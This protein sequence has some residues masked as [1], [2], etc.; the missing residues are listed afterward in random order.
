MKTFLSLVGKSCLFTLLLSIPLS[1]HAQAVYIVSG[2]VQSVMSEPLVGANVRLTSVKQSGDTYGMATDGKGSFAIQLPQGEYNLEISYLGY[3]SYRACVQVK[4]DVRLPVISLNEESQMMETVV[5]TAHTMTY[6]PNGYVAEIAKNPSYRG[7]SLNE[8]LKLTPGTHTTHNSVQL[9]GRNVS[10]IYLNGREL[11]LGGEQLVN[12][13]ETLDAKN[14]KR[15]EV[16][17]ASGVEEDAVNKGRSVI[18]ITTVNPETGGMMNAGGSY[19]NGEDKHIPL[20]NAMLRWRINK[21]WGTYFSINGA[22]SDSHTG[23]FTET[24]FYATDNR[25][26]VDSRGDSDTKNLNATLGLSYD[27][28]A[29][30]LFS[31][32]GFF[33]YNEAALKQTSAMHNLTNNSHALLAS[34]LSD[35]RRGY[36]KSN[37][38]FGYTHKFASQATLDIKAD[39]LDNRVDDNDWLRY[40]YASGKETG[41]DRWNDGK[42]RVYTLRADYNRRFEP[43]AGELSLGAKSTW[44]TNESNTDYLAMTDG[45]CDETG[46]YQDRYKYTE[47][48]YALYAKYGFTLKAFSMNLGIRMEHARIVPRSS[49]NPERNS[50][51]L[52]TDFFPEVRLSY[53][54]NEEKGHN[55]SIGYDRSL[56]RPG[57]EE[58]NP[59]VVRLNE[60]SYSMGN[61]SLKAFYYDAINLTGIFY[62][63][64]SLN[65][66]AS[67]SDDGIIGITEN[68]DGRLYSTCLNG[69]EE[70]HLRAHLSIPVRF[71]KWLNVRFSSSYSYRKES[72]EADKTSNNHWS[73][74]YMTTIT[75]PANFRISHSLS[76]P[77]VNSKT[78]YGKHIERPNCNLHVNKLFPKQRLTATLMMGDLF[79]NDGSR[80]TDTFRDDFYQVSRNVYSNFGISFGLRYMFN[81]GR[82][83][84]VRQGSSGNMEE[85]GR[86]ATE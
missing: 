81:W 59:L 64:Y 85:S 54:L 16:I 46:S 33:Q 34:G 21:Q 82:K 40:R 57:M 15:I 28:N 37:L 52:S 17:T 38:S 84:A 23:S 6:N 50:R 53:T 42:N 39:R 14:V 3:T 58:L 68:R 41:S 56:V 75:L 25:H 26:T 74:G 49:S 11:Q 61:P 66:Y 45:Q 86:F 83:S 47:D 63:K 10:K 77:L 32:E 29:D 78:L 51:N 76:Y 44:F 80:R 9:F 67:Y 4:G 24:H 48:V 7:M 18:K 60:Y 20:M 79:N 65:I 55:I 13:L 72:Y 1:L 5:V 27:L 19:M 69:K 12:Y 2:S 43:L 35:Y 62:R 70:F 22:K 73:V 8:I 31:L 30:N 71:A 36:H